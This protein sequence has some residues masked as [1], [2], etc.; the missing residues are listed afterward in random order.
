MRSTV[1]NEEIADLVNEAEAILA[2]QAVFLPLYGQPVTAA[3]WADEIQGFI[4]NPTVA[5]FTWNVEEWRR[6]DLG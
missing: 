3:I 6:A 4:L 2:D 1:D 5:G